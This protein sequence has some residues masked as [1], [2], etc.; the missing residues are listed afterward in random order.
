MKFEIEDDK[1]VRQ[2]YDRRMG[3]EIDGGLLD[4]KFKGYIFRI[5]GGN[6]KQGFTMKQGIMVNG[7]VK[8]LM[9]GRVSLYRPRCSGERKR[10]SARGC[11][12]GPDLAV[13]ALKI[14]KKGDEEIAGLTDTEKPRRLGPKRASNIRKT[15]MLR[16]QDDVTKYVVRREVKRG[17]K[18]FYKSPKVQRLVTDARRQRKVALKKAKIDNW[19]RSKEQVAAFEKVVS[20]YVKE[21]K[22]QKEAARKA[23]AEK[24]VAAKK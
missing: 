2:I 9:R 23:E 24:T 21:K 12:C 11:I 16:K 5:T 20:Q 18:T 14:V 10:K 4:D 13:I 7:R 3:S 22:A 19:K 17:D 1:K 6:D 8:V 15:F